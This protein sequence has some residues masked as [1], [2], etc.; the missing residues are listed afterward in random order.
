[1]II[2]QTP[3]R[4]S[5]AG[6]GTDLPAF[7]E[8]QFGAVFSVALRKH[9]YVTVG[10]RF[11]PSIRAAYSKAE[12][13][14]DFQQLQHTIMREALR[15]TGLKNHLEIVTIGDVPAGTGLGSSSTLAVGL[16]HALHAYK[17]DLATHH[18]MAE[19]ACRLE[20]DILGKPIGRQDQYAAAFGGINYIRFNPGHTVDVEPIPC[21]AETVEEL[22]KHILLLYTEQKRDA[23]NILRKQ[24]DGTRDK[25]SVLIAMRD[26]AWEMA[27]SV[28]GNADLKN[29]AKLLHE[30]WQLK[31][32]LGFGITDE[33]IDCWY[34]LACKNGALGGKLL[35]AG[36][37]G[38]LLVFAPPERHDRI[39]G[40]L[41]H[42]REL[43][44]KIDRL[45][46]RIIFVS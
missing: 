42:P 25:K 30:G 28:S 44:F 15:L 38:F 18:Q 8:E 4:V 6:G 37:G 17:G 39:R 20:I 9:M 46:S 19:E 26:L 11:E 13:V 22:E 2:T 41:N 34:D 36:G 12:I 27:K 24:S 1:M 43:E 21:R 23:D 16:L 10:P 40:A 33:R 35:G 5:F 3:Y 14:D 29:F 31:R 32:S 45:G 7:Y